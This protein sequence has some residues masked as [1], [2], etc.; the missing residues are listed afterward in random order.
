MANELRNII[1]EAFTIAYKQHRK[2]NIQETADSLKSKMSSG[3][4]YEVENVFRDIVA[5]PN[6][7]LKYAWAPQGSANGELSVAQFNLL[8]EMVFEKTSPEVKRNLMMSLYNQNN[9]ALMQKAAKRIMGTLKVP[10]NYNTLEQAY[11]DG[12]AQMFLDAESKLKPGERKQNF[13]D[14]A[15]AYSGK[16]ILDKNGNLKDSNFGAYVAE[17]LTSNILNA[18]REEMSREGASTSLDKPNQTTGKSTDVSD[19]D[20]YQDYGSDASVDTGI[21]VDSSEEPEVDAPVDF[22]AGSEVDVAGEEATA[23][24]AIAKETI[25]DIEKSIHQAI[26]EYR[27]YEEPSANQEKGFMALEAILSGLSPK[28]ASAKLGFNITTAI[29]DLKKNKTFVRFVDDYMLSNGV[30]NSRGKS[31]SFMNVFP[32]WIAD[33]IKFRETGELPADFKDDRRTTTY[34]SGGYEDESTGLDMKQMHNLVINTKKAVKALKLAGNTSKALSAVESLLTGIDSETVSK[35]LGYGNAE[36]LAQD[37]SSLN[38]TTS[39]QDIADSARSLKL[40][41]PTKA[42]P[43]YVDQDAEMD[44]NSLNE[45]STFWFLQD[46]INER[47]LNKNLEKIME[48]VYKRLAPK[49]NS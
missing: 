46:V 39:P 26:E 17:I 12:W 49:L 21:D 9:T 32:Q 19:G 45:N 13:S 10:I 34:A 27:N 38:I 41:K 25:T 8:A 35:N 30:L 47:F 15:A 5:N 31:E 28:D 43:V 2:S 44:M 7:A 37:I 3:D 14:I 29:Q 24:E 16:P 4:V 42:E 6:L 33:S 23:A 22:E 48:R 20:S 11:M 18:Y 1:R 36:E 40:G